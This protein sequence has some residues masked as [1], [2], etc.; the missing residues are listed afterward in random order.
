MGFSLGN[1]LEGAGGGALAGGALGPWGAIAGGALGGLLGGFG[2]DNG[3]AERRAK[4]AELEKYYGSR[5]APQLGAAP[6]AGLSSFRGNQGQLISQ[7]EAMSRGMG[8]SA[9]TVASQQALDRA[10]AG[11]S[12][13]ANSGRGNLGANQLTAANN[14]AALGAQSIRDLGI[15]RAQE[16]VGAMNTLGGVLQGARGADE[17]QGRFNAGAQQTQML[18]NLDAQLRTMGLND[19]QRR[20]ILMAQMGQGGGPSVGDMLLGAGGTVAGMGLG[21][22][23]RR[24]QG[25][26]A[27]PTSAP[28]GGTAIPGGALPGG[29]YLQV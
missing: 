8:P 17:T 29:G 13:M 16:Q 11:Q 23:G 5:E 22:Y 26:E 25:Q 7:L 1:A 19:E 15:A 24:G 3:E 10:Q 27:Y 9:A 4:L 12:S 18:A 28:T 14:S 6:Q 20:A 21:V 2:G